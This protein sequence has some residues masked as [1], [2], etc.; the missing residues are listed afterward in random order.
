MTED[1]AQVA[2]S[3]NLFVLDPYLPNC[4]VFHVFLSGWGDSLRYSKKITVPQH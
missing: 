4:N 1:L 3:G 2:K